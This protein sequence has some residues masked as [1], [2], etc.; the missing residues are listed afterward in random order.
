MLYEL[1][2]ENVKLKILNTD[3]FKLDFWRLDL[4][5]LRLPKLHGMRKP[6]AITI[7]GCSTTEHKLIEEWC[8][9]NKVF[10]LYSRMTFLDWAPVDDEE[11][12]F[13]FTNNE[14]TVIAEESVI[15]RLM[16]WLRTL[17]ERNRAILIDDMTRQEIKKIVKDN[18]AWIIKDLNHVR[19]AVVLDDSALA[20]EL[21]LKCD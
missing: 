21:I 19:Y 10:K 9:Q 4:S 6:M 11:E 15:K 14:R 1:H 3:D 20:F 8:K 5:C 7:N 2:V 16:K 13:E 18:N 17:P 12:L